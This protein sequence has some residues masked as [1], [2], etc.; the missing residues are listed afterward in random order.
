MSGNKRHISSVLDEFKSAELH[1][2]KM[3]EEFRRTC[4]NTTVYK[5]GIRHPYDKEWTE[6]YFIDPTAAEKFISAIPPQA[7]FAVTLSHADN[8]TAFTVLHENMVQ[9][10]AEVK[11]MRTVVIFD[12]EEED[13]VEYVFGEITDELEKAISYAQETYLKKSKGRFGLGWTDNIF[14][15]QTFNNVKDILDQVE[16]D[17]KSLKI[18]H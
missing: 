15:A 4:N 6:K 1:A 8:S 18:N 3:R 16:E 17:I 12:T 11:F 5:V 7:G 9:E 2:K 14:N 13:G 10:S